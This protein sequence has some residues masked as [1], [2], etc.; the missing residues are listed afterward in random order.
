MP[1]KFLRFP[2]PWKMCRDINVPLP[3]GVEALNRQVVST[4]SKKVD[5]TDGLTAGCTTAS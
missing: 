3:L 4:F 2:Q 1:E 5:F